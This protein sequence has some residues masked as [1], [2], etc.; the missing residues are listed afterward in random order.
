MTE[1]F[2]QL[3]PVQASTVAAE[4]D[5]LYFF[6]IAVSVVATIGIAGAL[7][8]FSIRYRRRAEDEQTPEIHGS[9][10]LEILWSAIPL[11][12]CLVIFGWGASLYF[13][14]A[15]PPTDALQMYAVGKQW[16]WKFQHPDGRREINQ[17]HVPIGQP[18]KLTMSSEDVIHSFFV[19]AFR[20]KQDVVPGRYSTVW[21]EATK[22]GEYHLFCA[23]YCGTLHSGMIGQ[24]IAMEPGA[25]QTWQAGAAAG[26]SMEKVGE[27]LFTSLG[28]AACHKAGGLGPDL[29]GVPGKE[30][31]LASGQTVAA[32]DGYLRESI[33]HPTAKM[34]AGY[35]PIMP[36]FQGQV[37]EEQVLQLIA[38]LKTLK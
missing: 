3:L 20:V 16:M 10:A 37:S 25:F 35:Q 22:P 12:I 17:L 27:G 23:E 9:L 32:D 26:Q 30:R 11:A 15:R 28:C 36:I 2:F 38:Y 4:V 31:A 8:L 6:L 33:L 18:V 13:R 1:R 24:V 21:F 5:A 7:V 29:T 19:P 14:L 34:V